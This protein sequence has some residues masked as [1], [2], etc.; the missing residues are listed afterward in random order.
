MKGEHSESYCK[1]KVISALDETQQHTIAL[2]GKCLN[3]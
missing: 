3:A 2:M 1:L